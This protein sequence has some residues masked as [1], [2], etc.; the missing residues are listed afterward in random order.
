[1]ASVSYLPQASSTPP[2]PQVQTGRARP[3]T[4]TTAAAHARPKPAVGNRTSFSTGTV[5]TAAASGDQPPVVVLFLAALLLAAVLVLRPWNRGPRTGPD[6]APA[7]AAA[8]G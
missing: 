4:G 8:A 3:G 1:M 5:E 6:V 2:A 7:P